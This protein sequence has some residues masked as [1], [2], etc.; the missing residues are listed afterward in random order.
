[1]IA[2]VVVSLTAV[3]RRP[4]NTLDVKLAGTRGLSVGLSRAQ[5]GLERSTSRYMEILRG[6]Q[7]GLKQVV[8]SSGLP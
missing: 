2:V 1:M 8:L 7:L 4:G 5:V 6:C 3:H